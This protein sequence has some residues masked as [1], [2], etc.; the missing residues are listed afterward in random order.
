[1]V[2]MNKAFLTRLKKDPLVVLQSM[3]VNDVAALIQKANHEY[4]NKAPLFSD[5]LFDIIKEYLEKKAPDHPILRNIGAAVAGDDARKEELPYVMA[6]LEKIKTDEKVLAK[7][8]ASDHTGPYVLSDK[9]D[10]ISA[11]LHWKGCTLK[12]YTRGDGKVGQNISHLLTFIRGIPGFRGHAEHAVRGEL[13]MSKADFEKVKDR[14]ANAR[15]MVA[16]LVNAKTPDLT[17]VQMVQFVAYE[18]VHPKMKPSEQFA[19]LHASGYKVADHMVI[20]KD[21]TVDKLSDQLVRRRQDGEFEIDGIVVANDAIYKR[22]SG[23]PTY[24]FAFKSIHTME[25]AEV[26]V[27]DV[28]WNLSKDGYLIPVVNFGG[29]RLDG[30]VIKRATGF[31]GKYIK[32]NKIGPGAKLVIIRSGQVIPY[33]KE[34]LKPSEPQMPEV[35]YIWSKSGVDI[36]LAKDQVGESTEVMKK[37][38][39][40]LFSKLDVAGMGPGTV[41]KLFDAGLTT[42]RAIFK[43]T[44]ADLLKADGIKDKSAE[45][46]RAALDEALAALDCLKLM[47]ASNVF[48]R[49]IGLKK[50]EAIAKSCPGILETRQVPSM[51][52]LLAVKGIEKTTAEQFLSHLG[53]FFKFADDNDF[54]CASAPGALSKK[55]IVVGSPVPTVFADMKIVFTGFRDKV[56]E[57][58]ITNR[59]GTI[60]TSVSKNTSIIVCKDPNEDSGKMKKARDLGLKIMSVEAFKKKYEA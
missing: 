10:G 6:S 48:G 23:N 59:G 50:L 40:N 21:L 51:E 39:E 19:Q 55:P 13:I 16:G 44:K 18:V 14:G 47:D 38:L 56:L 32:D 37:N 8:V 2:V 46:T 11:L 4:Y 52:E 41:K 1:M 22:T 5:E 29:V 9:L 26:L 57:E 33:V 49:G 60:T 31:N 20:P 43:A 36:M 54:K 17:L 58:F 15:N 35:P 42:P 34:V 12:M 27:T 28:E 53:A 45:K 7:W 30:V 24:A 25:Q 3:S